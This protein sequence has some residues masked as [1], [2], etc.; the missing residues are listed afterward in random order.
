MLGLLSTMLIG[1]SIFTIWVIMMLMITAV[2]IIV[3]ALGGCLADK[4]ELDGFNYYIFLIAFYIV[5]LSIL[6]ILL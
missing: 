3:F 1:L 4:L 6:T 5:I 2:L